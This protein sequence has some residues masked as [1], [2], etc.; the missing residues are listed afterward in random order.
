MRTADAI[1]QLVEQAVSAA[2]KAGALPPAGDAAVSIEKPKQA[3]HGDF[4]T[5][6]PLT[7]ARAM[8]M[9]PVAIGEQI[10]EHLPKSGL[11][12]RAWVAPPG[13][14]NFSV[15]DDWLRAQIDIIADAADSYGSTNDGAGQ[16]V[17][18]EFVSVNPTGPLH[19][20]H[21]RG[22]VLGS[23]IANV[24]EAAGYDV[25]REYLVN[26]A[27]AQ[28]QVFYDTFY[29]R[30]M[31]A[32]GKDAPLPD[33]AYPGEYLIELA[34][35]LY[36]ERPEFSDSTPETM[37]SELGPVVVEKVL[38]NIRQVLR[39]LNIEYDNWFYESSLIDG[40]TLDKTLDFL[41]EKGVLTERDGARWFRSTL[42]GEE[43]DD[44]VVR[45]GEPLPTY[46]G[47]D[48]AYHYDKFRI[49]K[50]D[51]VINV[52]GADH[53]GHVSRLKAAV[54]ALGADEDRL[55]VILNQL[56]SFKDGGKSLKFSKRRGVIVTVEQLLDD[57]GPDACRF[58]FLSRTPN[59]QM[60]FDLELATRQSSENPVFYVQY[61]HA[62]LAS[63]LRTARDRGVDS[64]GADL[65]LLK[66]D[67]ELELLRRL[68]EL[69]DIVHRAARNLEPHHLP[70]YAMELAKTLQRFYE[71]CRV[72][73][74]DDSEMELSKARLRLVEAARVVLA[75]T[76]GIMG[77]TAPDRM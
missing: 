18:V 8:R 37:R 71:Q 1:T 27:G 40:G 29:A 22:A 15:S 2:Q 54:K 77:M 72:L 9:A 56:V 12:G 26:D 25:Q 36:A 31:Q 23:G 28:M 65:S 68:V 4:S 35:E 57:V 16:R 39:R 74:D 41:E 42:Y 5:S 73:S 52:W 69:P 17:Q 24:L 67:A 11:V 21:A 46:F 14:V 38:A 64:A 66:H 20:G 7:L 60:E 75:R 43:K 34:K 47:T 63:I 53:H 3:E 44:V 32:A 19:V 55:T 70:H 30:Y 49:R 48:L 51:R 62:R 59:S 33:P 10:V 13:F 50:F 61:A 45:S 76:L 58:I 6:A